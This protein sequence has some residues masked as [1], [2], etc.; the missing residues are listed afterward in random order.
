MSVGG[1]GGVIKS[2]VGHSLAKDGISL[3]IKGSRTGVNFGFDFGSLSIVAMNTVD[4]R[5][6]E[7][8]RKG[9]DL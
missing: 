5:E 6:S 1:H 8:W 2:R 3:N 9:G 7:R 4:V